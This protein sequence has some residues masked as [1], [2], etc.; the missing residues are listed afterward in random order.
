MQHRTESHKLFVKENLLRV[1]AEAESKLAKT[2]TRRT[3]G[4]TEKK[5]KLHFQFLLLSM[6]RAR[7]VYYVY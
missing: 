4:A 5:I 6:L 1:A 7:N 3:I 2:W